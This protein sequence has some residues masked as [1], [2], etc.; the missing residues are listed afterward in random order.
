MIALTE[1]TVARDGDSQTARTVQSVFG[2]EHE[3]IFFRR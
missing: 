1:T 2:N 3:F